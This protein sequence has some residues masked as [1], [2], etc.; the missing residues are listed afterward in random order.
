MPNAPDTET[1]VYFYGPEF[2]VLSNFAAFNV[3]YRGH[4]FDTSEQA[5]HWAK[6]ALDGP[7]PVVC[8]RID[9]GYRLHLIRGEILQ[10]RSAHDAFKLAEKYAAVRRHD[11]SAVR[12]IVMG[13]ILRRKA[14]QHEYVR[15]K[16]LETGDRELIEDSWR[17]HF[18]GWGPNKDGMNM[19]GKLWTEIRAELRERGA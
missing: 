15:R 17:D 5:Y 8:N 13:D 14:E 12:V 1:R 11:W 16:L 10:A 7:V 2:Y 18:W 3:Y 9:D 4:D 19:L 6:F